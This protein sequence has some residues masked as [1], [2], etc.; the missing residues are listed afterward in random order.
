MNTCS[1]E[2]SH[3]ERNERWEGEL[4][5]GKLGRRKHHLGSE[6]GKLKMK[7]SGADVVR[8]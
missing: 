7:M 4:Q 5:Q 8:M 2:W 6:A 1:E 3:D